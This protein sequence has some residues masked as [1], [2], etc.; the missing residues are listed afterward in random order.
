MGE[1]PVALVIIYNHQFLQNIEVLERLYQDRFTAIYHLVPFYRGEKENVIPVYENSFYFQGYVA[2]GV[3]RF[4]RR[5]YRHYFFIA[6]DLVLNPLIDETNYTHFLKL[7]ASACFLP[8][9]VL[10]HEVKSWWERI[11][12]AYHYRRNT[13]GVEVMGLLPDYPQAIEKFRQF[14][15]EVKPVRFDQVWKKPTNWKDWTST[16]RADKKYLFR[17]AKNYFSEGGLCPLSYPLVGSYSDIFVISAATIKAFSHYCGIF[18]A[19][20]LFVEL[21]IP[22]A[23]VFSATEIVTEKSLELQGEALWTQEQ[24]KILDRYQNRLSQLLADFPVGR[25]YVH[26]VKL[27]QWHTDLQDNTL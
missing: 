1:S 9:L 23:L 21:A 22:T 10:L 26:P 16:L 27:S 12:E 7:N 2:Q 19:T 4:F 5:E 24:Y 3:H 17:R 6:D 25:L 20:N 8:E 15:L 14:N 18:A 11:P 13:Y